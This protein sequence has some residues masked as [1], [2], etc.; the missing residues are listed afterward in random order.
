MRRIGDPGVW[1]GGVDIA[2]Y[3]YGNSIRVFPGEKPRYPGTED[4]LSVK[5]QIKKSSGG[6][7]F[8]LFGV[9]LSVIDPKNLKVGDRLLALDAAA[10]GF[11]KR[12]VEIIDVGNL[13]FYTRILF[14]ISDRGFE[15]FMPVSAVTEI[16]EQF[17]TLYLLYDGPDPGEENGKKS[18]KSFYEKMYEY[19]GDLKIL[20]ECWCLALFPETR[21]EKIWSFDPYEMKWRTEFREIHG[22]KYQHVM[23]WEYLWQVLVGGNLRGIN[24]I[25]DDTNCRW[26]KIDL[27]TPVLAQMQEDILWAMLENNSLVSLLFGEKA[28]EHWKARLGVILEKYYAPRDVLCV[29]RPDYFEKLNTSDTSERKVKER[30]LMEKMLAI[31]ETSHF[32]GEKEAAR[33]VYEKL[34]G[35]PLKA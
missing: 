2:P 35:K 22:S 19:A 10:N 32:E 8:R 25:Y 31:I 9:K 30:W 21:D 4:F 11:L 13:V 23:V 28:G 20:I 17:P 15:G 5:E 6:R 7:L 3:L 18:R 14:P 27:I 29:P 24:Q 12:I 1:L 34:A 33:R 16:S 26:R